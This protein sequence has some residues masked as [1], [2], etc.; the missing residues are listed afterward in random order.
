MAA[1][2]LRRMRARLLRAAAFGVTVWVCGDAAAATYEIGPTD[3]LPAAID[4]LLPGDEL[5]LAGGTYTLSGYFEIGVSGESG[6]PI[7]IRAAEGEL[8]VLQQTAAQNI[9]NVSGS[10][11]TL[12]GLE[13]TGGDRGIRIQG[14]SYV[15]VEDCHVHD[16]TANAISANDAGV[17]YAG[18]VL[19]RNHIHDT[20]GNGEGMYLGCNDAACAFHDGVIE[21][22]WIHDTNG[23][24]VDQGD[25]IEIKEGSYGNV[26]RDNVIH[27]TGYP[28][29]IT[30]STV[31]NGPPNVV[32]RNVMWACG[33][34]GIQSA[35]D[36][37]I[38]NNIVL[39]AA[40]DG[41][42]NQ[43]HQAGAPANLVIS[44]NTILAPAGDAIRSDGIV[45][46]LVIA[47]NAVYAQ[48]GNAIRVAGDLSAVVTA[49]NLGVGSVVGVS[50]GFDASG[51]LADF[52]G[53]SFSGAPPNDV[54]PAVGSALIGAADAAYLVE[55]D[56][57]GNPRNGALDVGAYTSDPAGNPGWVIAPGFKDAVVGQGGEGG[58][59]AGGGGTGG[60]AA[61]G[62]SANGGAAPSGGSGGEGGSDSD[63][64][65]SDGCD[66]AAGA[67]STAPLGP[68]V[69]LLGA[70][71]L[72]RRRRRR[73]R[74]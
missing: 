73:A 54:F 25:G 47:N 53:A 69:L 43:P 15:T 60:D 28:C 13:L 22:N 27:D 67:G 36:A 45:G 5:V 30:Y 35:A 1:V 9:V 11:L 56:F 61:G 39:G 2:Y 3:D 12:R 26:V 17:D 32:E 46:S 65:A 64:G 50:S 71:A 31:G 49:G 51:G 41:I 34:H 68:S 21:G 14:A 7:V 6:A 19:R 44:H 58:G 23:P 37:I 29:I 57:N 48:S 4:A 16:T 24:T 33:D 10:Y 42:R 8:P 63:D 62:G 66:C 70:M 40:A 74:A 38:R 18:I 72:L 52:V 55:D 20:G 59:G